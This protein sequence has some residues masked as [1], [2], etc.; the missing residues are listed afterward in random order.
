MAAVNILSVCGSGTVTSS[1][2]AAKLKEKLGERGYSVSTTEARPTEALNLA[3]SG[4]FD[5]L[6]HTSPLQMEIME[7]Q[8][9]MLSLVLQEWGKISSLRMS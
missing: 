3:T 5:I 1:M 6:T 2:V 9:S 8:Q 7:S 4:R